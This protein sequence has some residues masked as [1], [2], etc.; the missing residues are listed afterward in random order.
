MLGHPWHAER[1]GYAADRE[2]ERVVAKNTAGDHFSAA[3][4]ESR[5]YRDLMAPPVERFERPEAEMEVVPARLRQI[6]ELVRMDVYAA[7]RHLVQQGLPHVGAIAV[8][9]GN[10][11]TA[12]TDQTL[13]E[14]GCELEPTRAAANHDDVMR[15]THV[16]GLR[17]RDIPAGSP[18]PL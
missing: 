3:L 8:D 10:G 17:S 15:V 16:F 1:V 18:G 2:H 6:V 4:V 11:R 7:R 9:E 12:L 14:A 13:P 5:C